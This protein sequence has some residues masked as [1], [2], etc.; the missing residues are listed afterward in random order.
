M[1]NK[2]LSIVN[3]LIGLIGL[4]IVL[5]HILK[6]TPHDYFYINNPGITYYVGINVVGMI[7]DLSYFTYHTM[8]IFSVWT[9][10]LG[11]SSILKFKKINKIFCHRSVVIF[12]TT[13]YLI[14]SFLYTI[15][16]LTSGNPTFGLYEISNKAI[17][18]FGIN[19][20]GHYLL[21]FYNIFL[22]VKL[23][24]NG[25]INKKHYFI[26]VSY[27]IVYYLYV[28]ITGLYMYEI[29][30]YPYPIFDCRSLFG[31]SN[32]ALIIYD[33]LLIITI[34]FIICF[35][36]YYLLRVVNKLSKIN[37]INV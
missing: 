19:I 16:E 33:I 24:F 29:V 2:I 17:H 26:M 15:F 6:F 22:F 8:I 18:N 28:K 37:K 9:F 20:I 1:K 34:L 32:D 12:I 10:L 27:L 14:T 35:G 23:K 25:D 3:I 4:W 30:W 36:Y 5:D 21:F 31:L 7:A 13:N 11:T